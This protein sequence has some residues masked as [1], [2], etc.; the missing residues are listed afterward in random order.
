MS[1]IIQVAQASTTPG[2]GHAAARTVTLAK[3]QGGQAITVNLDGSVRLDFSGIASE[4]VT[5]VRIGERLII[6]FDNQSTVAVEPFFE[7]GGAPRAG[8]DVA[9]APDHV[10]TGNEFAGLFPIS[11]DQSILPAAGQGAPLSGASF[12]EH[13]AIDPLQAGTS[14]LGLLDGTPDAGTGATTTLA[15]ATSTPVIGT[16]DTGLVDEEG[17]AEGVVGG[18]GDS[19]GESASVTGSLAITAGLDLPITLSFAS[20]QPSL[21]GLTSGGQATAFVITTIAGQPAI[22]G[23]FAGTDPTAAANHVYTITLDNVGSGSYTFTLLQPLD[24]PITGTEDSID[25]TIGFTAMDA[26]GDSASATFSVSINDDSPEVGAPEAGAVVEDTTGA[27]GSESFVAISQT[28]SLDIS[29]GADDD[30]LADPNGIDRAVAFSGTNTTDAAAVLTASGATL[31]SDGEVVTINRISATELEGV[32]GG[33]VVFHLTLS[34]SA[35]GSYTFELT[36]NIDHV[37][38]SQDGSLT[39]SFGFTATDA[40]GDAVS[41]SFAIAIGDD[42]GRPT[43]GATDLGALSEDTQDTAYANTFVAST[44]TGSLAIAWGSDDANPGAGAIDRQVAFDDALDGA[45]SGLTSNGQAITYTLSAD[46]LTL[47]ATASSG[48][49]FPTL[50]TVFTVTLDDAGSGSYTFNLLDNLDHTGASGTTL[51]LTFGFTATDAD[52]DP[53]TSSFTVNVT[54]ETPVASASAGAQVGEPGLPSVQVDTRALGIDWNA[55]DGAAKHILFARDA[56]GHPVVPAGLT[57]DGVALAYA[58]VPDGDNERL[59]AYKAGEDVDHPVFSI[60]FTE[61]NPV[62]TFALYQNLDHAAGADSVTIDFGIQAVDGD[63]DTVGQTL[64]VV[65]DD[66]VPVIGAPDAKTLSEDTQDTAYAN[67][68][69]ASAATGSLAIAWGSDDANPGAGTIDRQVAFDASLDGY[70]SGLTSNGQAITYTLSADHLT[71]TATASSGGAFPTLRTVFTVTLDDAGSGSY[72]FNLLDNLDHTGASGT[73]LPL[74]FGFT[75]TDAD[76]DPATSSFTVNVTDETPVASASAG[77]QVGEPGLPSVQV[78]TRALGIDWNADDGAAKHILF[79]RDADGHPVVPAGLTSDGVA[80]AYAIVPDGDNERLVA[81]KAGE[82]AGHPVF[83]IAFTEANPVY[84]FALYQNLDHA[85]GAD[86]VTIDFGIQAVDGDGDTIAG[87]FSV[88][89]VDDAPVAHNVAGTISE[90]ETRTVTLVEGTDYQLG[91]DGGA[92]TFGSATVDHGPT[93]VV[94]GLPVVTVGGDGHSIVVNPGTAFDAL[95]AGATALLHIPYVITDGDGDT[96]AREITLTVTGTNDIPAISGTAS[97]GVTEDVAVQAGNIIATAGDLSI[98]DADSGQSSFQAATIGGSGHYGTFTIDSAGHW[99]YAAGN[100]QDAVQR[101]AQGATLTDTFTVTSAD[102]SATRNVVITIT[103]TNDAPVFGWGETAAP[104]TEKAGQTGSAMVLEKTGQLTFAD[105]DVGDTHTSV[106]VTPVSTTNPG[107]GFLGSFAAWL[108]RE[109]NDAEMDNGRIDWRLSATD[110]S[111]DFLAEGQVVTQ[112]YTVTVTDASGATATRTITAK[113]TGR[114]D[115]PHLSVAAGDSDYQFLTETN[116]GLTASGTL[117]ATDVDVTDV[118]T[119]QVVS[120]SAGGAGIL[121]H[122][123]TAE[124]AS[125]LSVAVTDTAATAGGQL[126]WTFNSGA[127]AFDFLPNGWES[128]I[129]YT[130]QVSDGNG[131]TDQ[132]VVQIKLHG[133][134]DIPVISGTASGGVTED[135]AVQAG[136]I[137]A[138]AGDLSIVDADSGQSSFQAATIGGSGHYG[139]FTIDSA[140][141]WTY[142]AGNG[143]DAVQRLAQGATLTDTFTVTSADGS[144][145]RNVVITITGTNDAPVFGWGETAAPLTEKAGQTGSAM[146][147]EKTGQLTFADVDV[148]DTHTSV[149]V[150]PVSTTNPG[151]GFLGSFAAWLTREPNDAEMDNGRI[152][153]RLSATD[154]SL[155]FLAEGQVVTQVYTVTVTDASGATATR[156]ITAKITGREDVPH[157]SVAAGDSDYQFLTET[158]AGLTASGTLTA[159]DV[160]VT[161]VLTAQVVSVSAGG[162]GILSHVTTAELASFLSVAVTDTAATAG[163]QLQWTFNSGTQAFDFLPNGW[164]SVIDYTIQVNDGHGGTDQHVVQIKLHGTNDAPVIT[165]TSGT[166][167]AGTV[168]ESG[169]IAGIGEAGLGSGLEPTV[170]L[171]ATV[172]TALTSLQ[173]APGQVHDVVTT[174]QAQ[175]GGDL[176]QAIAVVWD[177]LDDNYVAG[178]PTQANINEAFTRLG[179]EY[180]QYLQAG[181]MPLVDVI[182]KYAADGGDG[183]TL[184]DRIQ[185]LHDNLLGNLGAAA[186][187]QRY[188]TTALHDELQHQIETVDADLLARPYYSGNEGASDAAVRAWDIANG[189]VPAASG[190]LVAA[191][192]D[193]GHTLTWSISGASA[194]GTMSIDNASGKWTYRLADA[195]AD[196]QALRQGQT[197]TETFAATVTDEFGASDTQTVTITIQGTNDAPVITGGVAAATVFEAGD[198]DDVVEADVGPSY[199]FEPGSNLDGVIAPFLSG[200]PVNMTALLTAVQAALPTTA[201]RADAIAAVWDYIDDNYSYYANIINE[202]GI[203]LGLA[204]ADYLKAGGHPLLDVVAKYAPDGGDAGSLPDRLQSLHDNLLGNLE[205]RSIDDKL[206]GHGHGGS[207]PSPVAPALY[208]ELSQAIVTAGLSG[209]PIYSGNEGAANDALAWDMAH[210]LVPAA[211]GTLSASDV[212]SGH[213]L[214]WSG[215]ANGTY[216]VF[217]IDAASGNWTYTLDDVRTSTQRLK[218]GQTVTETFA[219]TVTDE[220]GASDTQTVTI[221]IQGTNDAPVITGGIAA[222]TVTESGDIAGIGEAGLGS[223]LE[224]TVV[225]NA[226]VTTALTSLQTA[227]GQVHDV[228]TTVQAQLGGDLAQAIA[229]VW[230]YLDD[231]YV[232]GG[233]T[234]AN[235][236]EAFTR[237]GIEYAQ[238]LQAGGMPL[239]DVIAKYAA[240]GG[241]GGTLPDRI[242]S[243]HDN[244]LGNLGAAA[245]TQRYGT[246]A[247]HDELQHQIET[248][249]ADLLARPYYSGNEGASDAAV[250]AWDIANGYVPAASGQLVAADVDSG[251]VLNWSISGA[252]AYGTMSIDA[253]GK[254]TY[255]LDD[256]DA[257]T[258]ALRQGQTVTETFTATVTDEFGASAT[259]NVVVTIKGANDAPVI[260]S[261]SGTAVAG[262]VTESG[263]LAGI[264]EAGLGGG[265]EPTV[266]LNATVTTALA[267]LQT[268]PGQVHAVVA[269]V[270]AQLGGNL[271]QAIAVVWDYLDDNYVSGGPTQANINEAF[272][273][274]GIEYAQYLQA[275]GMP[276]V[277]VTAKY[278]ADGADGGSLPDRVQS[279]HDNLLGNLG[280]AALTQRYGATALHDELQHQ[281]E[282]VDA[283]LL[284]RPYYSG[285]EGASDAAVRAWD[286]ANGYVPAASGQLT[287]ADVDSGHA[288]TWSIS[289]ASAYGTMSIDASGK[290]TYR[291]DDADADTQALRQGQTVTETF[292]ATVTDEYGASATQNV[293]VTIKGTNDAPVI[294]G[295]TTA[296]Y[297]ER[298]G[299]GSGQYA[300]HLGLDITVSDVDAGADVFNK[301]VVTITNPVAGDNIHIFGNADRELSNGTDVHLVNQAGQSNQAGTSITITNATAGGTL[302]AAEVHEAL[303]LIRFWTSDSVPSNTP[304][305]T[306]SITVYDENGQSSTPHLVT[307]DVT[308]TNDT[309]TWNGGGAHLSVSTNE[310]TAFDLQDKFVDTDLTPADRDADGLA[311]LTLHVEHGTLSIDTAMA[312]SLGVHIVG[313]S[314]NSGTV[315]LEGPLDAGLDEL[316]VSGNSLLSGV[317]YRPDLHFNGTDQL[318]LTVDDQTDL[319]VGPSRSATKIIDIAVN[320]VNDAPDLV[321]VS[322]LTIAE[323]HTLYVSKAENWVAVDPDSIGAAVPQTATLTLSV[324]AGAGVFNVSQSGLSG[325]FSFSG[326]GT[327]TLVIT[328]HADGNGSRD[329]YDILNSLLRPD[330]Y[331]DNPDGGLNLNGIA[332]TPAANFNGDVTVNYALND[333]GNIGA[334]GA[335]TDTGTFSITVTPVNDAPTDISLDGLTLGAGSPAHTVI[336]NLFVTDVDDTAF[337]FAIRNPDGSVNTGLAVTGAP[338]H[339]QLETTGTVG[340]LPAYVTITATD[341]G[342]LSYSEDLAVA[343]PIRLV[344]GSNHLVGTFSTIQGAIDAASDG[345]AIEIPAGTYAENLVISGQ[346]IALEAI[347]GTVVVDPVSGVGLTFSGDLGGGDVTITGIDFVGGTRGIY[348]ESDAN[349]GTLAL[350]DVEISGNA[351]YGLRADGSSIDNLTLINGTFANNGFQNN[352]NGSAD[353]KL[354]GFTGDALFQHV[355]IDGAAAGTGQSDRPDYAIEITGMINPVSSPTPPIGTVVFDDVTVT[356]AFHKNGVAIYNFGDLDHLDIGSGAKGD[357]DLSGTTTN[358]GAVFNIDGI[359]DG[360]D[361]STYDIALPGGSTITTELQGD[362]LG[363][364]TTDQTITGTD[365]NDRLIGKGG[366]DHLIGGDGDDELYGHDKPGEP[367]IADTGNDTLEGNAGND[368]LSGGD[369]TDTALYAT[370]LSAT[371]ITIS[372]SGWQVNA[373]PGEGIDTL[374]DIEVVQGRD[375]DGAG[376]ATG[377]FLLV[378]NGGFTTIQEAVNAA[379]AGDTILIAAGTYAE[380]VQIEGAGKDGLSLIAVGGVVTIEAPATLMKTGDS[381]TSGRDLVALVSVEG[382]DG[383]MLKGITVD[384]EQRGNVSAIAPDN[385]TLV[386]IAYVGSDDGV[387]DGVK[388]IGIR[389]NDAGFGNQRGIGIYVANADPSPGTPTP[390]STDLLNDI[391]IRNS[392]I[393]D[394]QKGAIV[395]VNADVDIR[396]NTIT[397]IGSTGW[398]AQNGIQVSGSTGLISGNTVNAIGYTGASTTSTDILTF[399][400]LNLV[401]DGNHVF[402]TGSGTSAIGIAVINSNGATVTNNDIHHVGWAISADDYATWADA[403]LPGS[404]TEFTGNLF[405]GIRETYLNFRPAADTTSAFFVVGTD[406]PDAIYGAAGNDTITGAGGDDLITGRGGNDTID[407]GVGNDTINYQLGD[408]ADVVDGGA[409]D[410]TLSYAHAGSVAHNVYVKASG[411]D[412]VITPTDGVAGTTPVEVPV[413]ARGVEQ[414]DIKLGDWEWAVIGQGGGNFATTALTGIDVQG[415]DI[416][417]SLWVSNLSS[418][419]AVTADLKGGDDSFVGGGQSLGVVVEGG[420]G[421]DSVNYNQ[422]SQ[423]LVIDLDAGKA[424]RFTAGGVAVATDTVKSFENAEGSIYDDVLKG[425]A[426]ANTLIGGGGDD[427]LSGGAG[428]DTLYGNGTDLTNSVNRSAQSGEHDSA[429]YGGP[430]ADYDVIFNMALGAWQVAA[431]TTAPEYSTSGNNTDTLYGVEGIDFGGNGTVDIDL[432]LPVQLFDGSNN[433]LGT[434]ATLLAATTAAHFASDTTFTIRIAAGDVSIGGGQVVIDKNITIDGAG[435]SA[436]ELQADFDTGN[437]GSGDS[438]ALILVT[439][440]GTLHLSDLTIDGEGR[441]V[442]QAIRVAGTASVDDVRFE[443]IGYQTTGSPYDGVAISARQG[444]H[445]T[446]DDSQFVKIGRIGVHFYGATGTVS[447]SVFTGKGDAGGLD[448]LNYAVEAGAGAVINV[449]GNAVTG[450]LG[451]G[452]GAWTSAAFIVTDYYGTGTQATFV[453][454]TV[455]DSTVGVAAGYGDADASVIN[456]GTGN[457]FTSGVGV[458]VQVVGNVVASGTTNVTGTF[459]WEGGPG[460]NA[461]SGAEFADTLSGG[462]GTDTISGHGGADTLVGGDGDDILIGGAG[463]DALYGNAATPLT[464]GNLLPTGGENDT[465][466]YAGATSGYSVTRNGDGSFTVD[467]IDGTNGDEGTDTLYGIEGIDFGADGSVD[468][469]LTRPV[470]L[471]SHAGEL[472]A[473]Y[474]TIQAAVNAADA[475]GMT[476]RIA[477]GT[478]TEQVHV[479]TGKD[480]LSIIGESEGGVVIHAPITGL[481]TYASDPVGGKALYGVVTVTGSDNVELH[482]LTVDGDWQAEQV[483]SGNFIGVVYVDSAG[484]VEDVTIREIGDTPVSANQVSGNQRGV[485]LLVSN[486]TAEA[487]KSFALVD[488]TLE[489]FQKNGTVFRHADLTVTGNDVTGFGL[490]T[491]QAQNGIQVEYGATGTISGNHFSGIGYAGS[492]WTSTDLMVFDAAGLVVTGNTFSGV[493]GNSVGIYLQNVTG[494]MV[495]GNSVDGVQY[496]VEL[497]YG[498]NTTVQGNTIG[499]ATYGILDFVG[500]TPNNVVNTGATANSYSNISDYNHEQMVYPGTLSTAIHPVGSEGPDA[501][502]GGSGNDTLEGRGGADWLQ[503]KGGADTILGGAGDDYIYYAIGDGGDSLIDGG[504]DTDTLHVEG[505]GSA[506]AFV[507]ANGAPGQLAVSADGATSV[508]TN[509]EEIDIAGSGGAD[510]LTVSGSLAGTGLSTSTIRFGGGDG[511][512]TVDAS[513]LTSAHRIVFTGGAGDDTFKV[514]PGADQFDAGGG[515]DKAVYAAGFDAAS[516]DLSASTLTYGEDSYTG[517]EQLQFSDTTVLVVD[518][519]GSYDGAYASIGA[520]LAAAAGIAGHVTVVVAAGTYDESLTIADNVTI[521]G[522]QH[523]VEGV[524]HTGAETIVTGVVTLTGSAAVHIDGVEFRLTGTM[525][526]S[527]YSQLAITSAAGHVVENCRFITEVPAATNDVRAVFIGPNGSGAVTIDDNYFSGAYLGNGMYGGADSAS[528]NRGI[529]SDGSGGGAAGPS[530]TITGNVFDHV[531][532]SLNLDGLDNAHTNVSGNTFQ[533]VGTGVSVGYNYAGAP[534]ALTLTAVHDNKFNNAGDDFNLKN[535]TTPVNFDAAATHNVATETGAPVFVI[536]GGTGGDTLVGTGGADILLGHAKD[537]LAGNDSNMLTGLAGNDQLIGAVG[538]GVDTANYGG[539]LS[540]T[541]I[542]ASGSGWQVVAGTEGTDTLTDIEIVQGADPDGAAT[543]RFLLVGNGGFG[544]IQEAIGASSDGDTILI[545]AGTYREMLSIDDKDIAL[546]GQGDSTIITAPDGTIPWTIKVASSSAQDK[547]AIISVNDATVTIAD[548]KID[549]AGRGNERAPDSDDYNGIVMINSGGTIEDVTIT[550]VRAPL[551]GDG[552]VSGA[553]YGVGVYVNNADGIARSLVFSDNMI[554]D[555]QKNATAFTGTGL[556]VSVI[557]NIIIGNGGTPTIAQNGLQFSNG[558]TGTVDGNQISEIG[559][560]WPGTGTHWTATSIMSSG[561]DVE[562]KNNILAAPDDV[563]PA[564]YELSA[565][566]IYVLS[567]PDG[568][569][570]YSNAVDGFTQGIVSY[571]DGGAPTIDGNS[572]NGDVVN[573]YVY[574]PIGAVDVDGSDGVDIFNG[575]PGNDTFG[576]TGG[577]DLIYGDLGTD[578]LSGGAGADIFVFAET[579]A[580]NRDTILDYSSADG[581]KIDLTALLDTVFD[582]GTCNASD[583]VRAVSSAGDAIVQVDIDGAATGASWQDVAVLH[584]F[585]D[586]S[587]TILVQIEEA[588]SAQS[589]HPAV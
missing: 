97:G 169:D 214:T 262:T 29:W 66:S 364:A 390:T 435:M 561:A 129:D 230:D 125:F 541:S 257:D 163:G 381:P 492:G 198:L 128:V 173:T 276:L 27:A 201:G 187:T 295:T 292:T 339:Y 354:W 507:I 423:K 533:N 280:A 264:G 84:T 4:K 137:I 479:G 499:N 34:D 52:G 314:N 108:T 405:E 382:A 79:A 22:I 159:T 41:S 350:Q 573:L 383:V 477:N 231:N 332:F 205:Q 62:Y 538:T 143:Q 452:G 284:A 191:D 483:G 574:N 374:A 241:D 23:Y 322:N 43:I 117:T 91:A 82:D 310:D 318:T 551:D 395:V 96:V 51:P 560:F 429:A 1:A 189:Y 566:G 407:A 57:S 457:A 487:L 210:G 528:W 166:A 131:G 255:R 365:A 237:L 576:G 56:D 157:L 107:G 432:T 313:G 549:G 565:T 359:T 286:I 111:L 312:A 180:A 446:V 438:R 164:E 556:D 420:A 439:S 192:V 55:D 368:L 539:T 293:V 177:Y 454:N 385:G 279:L 250:R 306:L 524:S 300:A 403:L 512:D 203:R 271:A 45:A 277:D 19:A 197:V 334:G 247:L 246:T 316:L 337:T 431:K 194:Y 546:I 64:Q 60:A 10:V 389:E 347:S 497:Y 272:T 530:L 275:G 519:D 545:A 419:T 31:T 123:T 171:N 248:V 550:G 249:D 18:P 461:P 199:R 352:L 443:D 371:D 32:A 78:D 8:V 513:G 238:Y 94:L 424:A 525:P 219:A 134:N 15:A 586:T 33:R 278:A 356:G 340:T 536:D 305:R 114:E 474:A 168:T 151:G 179:I 501:Y 181:G 301:V 86:S 384:G 206:L 285:N 268:A 35:S 3:P 588:A 418:A 505:N 256:A 303:S 522:A 141:H 188:G 9:L 548:V 47:T 184:P 185:S 564:S 253:S 73:T 30:N 297:V 370:T 442:S 346:A 190:Q 532:S 287:A 520:A 491:G 81:Y 577:D 178:G 378:G 142:A 459:E 113:I 397:G 106:T 160:D 323:D 122:V 135:V 321:N 112:V 563:P 217:A 366:A 232:A 444:S 579:G 147:L 447:D 580:A 557:D 320:A 48:G 209:R 245:L 341:S 83:S 509:V 572:F 207:N 258:Q 150:T 282:T 71:L 537:A 14:G 510:T 554:V 468:L 379:S 456:F 361:A 212:D 87:S 406:G 59:V 335:L 485:A 344:D 466:Q 220:F 408:G 227:P 12:S 154:S 235:I 88:A 547:S 428:N 367:Q 553:Q 36:D 357:L 196:T 377:R 476:I 61:A 69:V 222:S 149:T 523:G 426:A 422:V 5:F 489:Q 244:L 136:N 526:A 338:G 411:A 2:S 325:S 516:I 331:D 417:N 208:D 469:D 72:T 450:H 430:A 414:L 115:V 518:K 200:S 552:H 99:T 404:G 543:G 26:T 233:P 455:T 342:G 373:E 500:A 464:G 260:T 58:I 495:S 478:Y 482:D 409:G 307:V 506:N 95:P 470:Q 103:G 85:V 144:A 386:G 89:I 315:V 326:Q 351:E 575:G 13:G 161:D 283:D 436:T 355:T 50:R 589:I 324:A 308:G 290:W 16:I 6:L 119:A 440:A 63:G 540:A 7:S 427:A 396:A 24:H 239:V 463:D 167:V 77:A 481:E 410:D 472:I 387:I 176:A 330:N 223:G 65:V 138:T 226:T 558:V 559:W 215:G 445:L 372:G 252:S 44:A 126:Q 441:L 281:V 11:T 294:T 515:N 311:R 110:S 490:Q 76:G 186:L 25:L 100:G 270:Q 224:P 568:A 582:S 511:N 234:Q 40:D 146:V 309:P 467:D 204:Y 363:Q 393:S 484:R 242:Q 152:D 265:L 20:S 274:L 348:V 121:S 376:I 202:A 399:H 251:H 578:T 54:D 145:T 37:G 93:G 319:G 118:L 496:G 132:H 527:G 488:S 105:V 345:Y 336:G 380:Q 401:I 153:W 261:T 412:V 288:L 155:D 458:G 400:N 17:L 269:A 116:A 291:L 502:V 521:L 486:D 130:I 92:I 544:S 508:V 392:T 302:T 394:F 343:L 211:G 42:A 218:E 362:K 175:L 225:L 304:D 98:V 473:T 434:Y 449:T 421:T 183:G 193:S 38:A 494:G 416:S 49:A 68:F 39:L 80:L 514:G 46:H 296:A 328:T 21:A 398:T 298:D 498:G 333:H 28:R 90:N 542:T 170:A 133:T 229:V 571:G 415:T 534:A 448:Y 587:N 358:W 102:G 585:G 451:T 504:A 453:G 517:V 460:T 569:S 360:Y 221:T 74:T 465:A 353:I 140:G 182:A 228:V 162:A 266:A 388:V 213:V 254:W 391:T 570:L 329:A 139:T 273:R 375:P 584:G 263:D 369:G 475:S 195:D 158:N 529:W 172:T 349:I 67:T 433:L 327:N 216:G 581:D 101:L 236:N 240:D 53:A 583:F 259:Q 124:L 148:G 120:V 267:S 471:F 174:V 425:T 480:G 243:L 289:G 555:F 402:G 70:A 104:L 535:I 317:T 503:G 109:P 531:R 567:D 493:G 156:T 462:D 413:T 165:S 75:A 299:D 127:Q 437:S 562:I